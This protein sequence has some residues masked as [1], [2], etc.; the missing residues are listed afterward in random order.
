VAEDEFESVRAEPDPLR[1]AQR[2]TALLGLY[3]QR[4]VELARLRKVAI[5]SAARERGLTLAAVAAEIGLSKGRITQIRQS[6]PPAERALFGVGPITVAVPLRPMPDRAL[7]VISAEDSIAAEKI[8]DQLRDLGFVVQP[9]RIPVGG[10]WTPPPGDVLAIAGPKSSPVPAEALASDPLLAFEAD[11]TGRYTITDRATGDR[12][13]S[14]MDDRPATPTDVAY[15]GRLPH[16]GGS[17]MLIAGVHAIGSVGVA[18]YLASHAAEIYDAVG[19][20][21]WSAVIR[22]RYDDATIIESELACPPRRH[23]P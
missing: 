21:H 4:S 3:Q 18:H 20:E 22:S 7:P 5:E 16:P 23:R 19:T 10:L 6:A 13:T 9:Y 14:G 8:T 15:I 12:Y 11:E 2:A 1:R 17:L